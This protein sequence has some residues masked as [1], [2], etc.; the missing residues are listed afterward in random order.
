MN[1]PVLNSKT[2]RKLNVQRSVGMYLGLRALSR[3]WVGGVSISI[4]QLV[5]GVF[6]TCQ[7][8]ELL[9][10]DTYAV[11]RRLSIGELTEESNSHLDPRLHDCRRAP[12]GK[13]AEAPLPAPSICE[14]SLAFQFD[15]ATYLGRTRKMSS[16]STSSSSGSHFSIVSTQRA[17]TKLSSCPLP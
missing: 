14:I 12:S 8:I 2:L 3:A 6:M 7:S 13:C 4:Y 1:G 5:K 9:R 11:Q 10:R 17:R 16:S 15:F